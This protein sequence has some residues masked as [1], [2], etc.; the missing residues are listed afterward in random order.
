MVGDFQ[1]GAVFRAYSEST[2][3]S[4]LIYIIHLE[5]MYSRKEAGCVKL[6][7]LQNFISGKLLVKLSI[8]PVLI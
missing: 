7:I 5:E 4:H 2:F 1:N 8:F 3:S 6:N